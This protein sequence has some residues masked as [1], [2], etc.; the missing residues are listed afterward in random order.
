MYPVL[1]AKNTPGCDGISNKIIMLSLSDFVQHLTI[2]YNL[3]IN[4]KY[5]LSD[6][7][8]AKAV[9]LQKAK[10]LT[11]INNYRPISVLSSIS[12]PLEKHVHK[13]LLKYLDRFN[14]IHT[15]LSGFRPQHSC[16]SALTCL[17]DRLLSSINDS[18]LNGA[19][20]LDLKKA[21]DL[22]DHHILLK[23]NNNKQTKNRID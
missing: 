3:C 23:N 15:H 16:Q 7:K 5:F 14:L 17:V 10:D 6:L 21:F 11:D 8:K 13:Y 9:P 18:E 4:H 1:V 20:F 19:V 22:I 2:V 12:K